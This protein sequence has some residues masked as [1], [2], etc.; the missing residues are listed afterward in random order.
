MRRARR[1]LAIGFLITALVACA[2]GEPLGPVVPSDPDTDPETVSASGVHFSKVDYRAIPNWR[3]DDIRRFLDLFLRS[4]ERLR[5]RFPDEAFGR[6]P[7]AGRVGEWVRICDE[8]TRQTDARRDILYRF[9][10]SRFQAYQVSESGRDTGLMTGYFETELNGT[11]QPGTD[12][13][14]PLYGLPD[15]LIVAD[16]GAF[17][18]EWADTTIAGRLLNGRYVPYYS[19]AEIN[20]GALHGRDLELI[21]V[22]SAVD[23]FFLQIQG[24]GRI[25]LADGTSVRVGYAGRNGHRYVSIGREL[26]AAGAMTLENVSMQSIRAWLAQHPRAAV[27]MMNRNPSYIFFRLL[28]GAGPVGAQGVPLTPERSLAVDTRYVPLGTPVWLSTRDPRDPQRKIPYERMMIAQDTGS[29]IR[30]GVRGDVFWG[31]GPAAALAAG[32]MKEPGML[33]V[34]WPRTA[35][36]RG[37]G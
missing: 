31:A 4:C 1:T 12:Y 34:L 2:S 9:L 32:H 26:V 3:S 35:A 13:P 37:P 15:D 22:D 28:Q 5:Q 8:A 20:A 10:E 29:A 30:G 11:R 36:D 18:H 6:D 25:R 23:A 33:Y 19:R 16:L 14:V 27:D 21:W 17:R 24:S 7:R